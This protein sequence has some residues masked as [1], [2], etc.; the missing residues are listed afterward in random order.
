MADELLVEQCC[1]ISKN[2]S[3]KW[4][5]ENIRESLR[6]REVDKYQNRKF[7]IIYSTTGTLW[8]FT[9]LTRF[10]LETSLTNSR[11]KHLKSCRSN[12]FHVSFW[13]L[14]QRFS[15]STQGKRS[16][17]LEKWGVVSNA[18]QCNA[19]GSTRQALRKCF[20]RFLPVVTFSAEVK[21]KQILSSA[22]SKNR[23]S[24]RTLWMKTSFLS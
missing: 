24:K 18:N 7:W 3:M 22:N 11:L 2:T 8:C 23:P 4:G 14:G 15:C 1:S 5:K 13:K 12:N 17:R 21:F 10:L 9:A 16:K 19:N 6:G 20:L